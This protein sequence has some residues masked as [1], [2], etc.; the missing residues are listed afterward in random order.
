MFTAQ[1]RKTKLSKTNTKIQKPLKHIT[2][3]HKKI[4][5]G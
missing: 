3:T 2:K 1:K 4:E 5:A